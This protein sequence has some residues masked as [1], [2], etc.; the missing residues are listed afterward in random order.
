MMFEIFDR[1]YCIH[2]PNAKRRKAIEVEFERVGIREVQY[3]H[4]ERPPSGFSMHNMRRAPGPEFGVS[5]S[6]IKAV[7]QAIAHGALCPL[8]VEDDIRFIDADR[9]IN[10]VPE[11]DVLYLGG[12]PREKVTRVNESWVKVGTWSCA[13]AYAL[14]RP[15]EFFQ[16]WCDRTTKPNAMYDF[17]LGEYAASQ[18]AYCVYPMMTEQLPNMSQVS[19]QVDDKRALISRGWATNL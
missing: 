5:L 12:H 18:K 10:E 2:L 7:V 4:A 8:F 19:G 11:W 6:H 15:H 17:I 16:F 13:E 9:Q 1:V 3:V 14:R